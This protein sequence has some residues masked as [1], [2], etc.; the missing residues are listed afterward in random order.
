MLENVRYHASNPW[1]I[2]VRHYKGKLKIWRRADY[3]IMDLE[4]I[5]NKTIGLQE[6]TDGLEGVLKHLLA[7]PDA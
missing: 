2:R 7:I 1:R 6:G 3:V 4:N 5:Q